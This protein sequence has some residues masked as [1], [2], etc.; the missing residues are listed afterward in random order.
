MYNTIKKKIINFIISCIPCAKEDNKSYRVYNRCQECHSIN[1]KC[2]Y[3]V[4]KRL[5]NYNFT[6]YDS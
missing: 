3:G 2:I 5:Q 1:N 4:C 6:I